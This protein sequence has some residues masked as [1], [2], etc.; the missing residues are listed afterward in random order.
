MYITTNEF[1]PTWHLGIDNLKIAIGEK[2]S[3]VFATTSNVF[4]ENFN[5]SQTHEH[6]LMCDFSLP[7]DFL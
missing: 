3:Y 1:Y 6:V 7:L 2:G 4:R 5:I